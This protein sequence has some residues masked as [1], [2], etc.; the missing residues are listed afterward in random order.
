MN[1]SPTDVYHW[2]RPVL[3]QRC[4]EFGL[5]AVRSVRELH[6]RLSTALKLRSAGTVSNMETIKASTR[7]VEKVL[8]EGP[9]DRIE[10]GAQAGSLETEISVLGELLR[11]VQPF[12]SDEPTEILRFFV[13]LIGIYD[14]QL[15]SDR[16][17]M[18]VL[19][20]KLKGACLNFLGGYIRRGDSWELCKKMVLEEFFP[21]IVKRTVHSRIDCF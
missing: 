8:G 3:E 21:F 15:A 17:F 14:L 9:S 6:E 19:L 5:E 18:M 16:L 10:S 4:V 13:S 20:P 1:Y 12:Q 7:S 11:N 2:S